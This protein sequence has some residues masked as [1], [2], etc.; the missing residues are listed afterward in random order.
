MVRMIRKD[1]NK[2]IMILEILLLENKDLLSL[3]LLPLSPLEVLFSP[4]FTILSE[5]F[6]FSPRDILVKQY[7]QEFLSSPFSPFLQVLFFSL[8]PALLSNFS[9][10]DTPL[11]CFTLSQVFSSSSLLCVDLLNSLSLRR[12]FSHKMYY[13]AKI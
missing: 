3:A 9:T 6:N 1:M 12:Y 13:I 8:F 10:S 7:E 11:S 4:S 2:E 5:L